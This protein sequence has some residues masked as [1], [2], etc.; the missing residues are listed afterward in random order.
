VGENAD[1]PV[2]DIIT[3]FHARPVPAL[4]DGRVP[5]YLGPSGYMHR[6]EPWLEAIRHGPE[7][8][9]W[10]C[11][12]AT[13]APNGVANTFRYLQ[14][15]VYE[16]VR[17][18]QFPELAPRLGSTMAFPSLERC[19]QFVQANRAQYAHIYIY[20][21]ALEPPQ[22][23]QARSSTVDMALFGVTGSY[24]SLV[25]FYDAITQQ[26]HH[27]WSS[28]SGPKSDP[29]I[30]FYGAVKVVHEMAV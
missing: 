15:A 17:Q 4:M 26:A 3:G 6:I 8:I 19:Q 21:V 20:E 11:R 28:A 18:D 24:T 5:P 30:L 16:S 13:I 27:Y 29:E 25:P 23:E 1:P 12:G 2:A 14:E 22:P 7:A 10:M 9:E